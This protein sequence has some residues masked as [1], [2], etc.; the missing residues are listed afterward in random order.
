L[1]NYLRRVKLQ[2][3]ENMKMTKVLT[4]MSLLVLSAT[5][6]AG[7][8]KPYAGVFGGFNFLSPKDSS[9]QDKSGFNLGLKGTGSYITDGWIFDLSGGYQYNSMNGSG[10][11][12]KTQT[13]FLDLDAR[14]RLTSQL[15][16]GPTLSTHFNNSGVDNTYSENEKVNGG[17]FINVLGGARLSYDSKIGD[18]PVRY[19]VAALTNVNDGDRRNMVINFGISFSLPEKKVAPVVARRE[20]PTPAPKPVVKAEPVADVKVTLKFA[21]VGFETDAYQ[22]D[23]QGKARLTKLGKVLAQYPTLFD[24]IKISGHTDSRGGKEY[25]QK[26]SQDRAESVLKVFINAGVNEKKLEAVG[27][28]LTR[29]LDTNE[30]PAAWEKNRRTEIEFFGVTDRSF[31]N[32]KLEEALK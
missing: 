32:K 19:D 22:L 1:K 18:F 15:S 17:H 9:E 27:Y 20:V 8:F 13:L 28:G 3:R 4:L 6:Q 21:R 24:R 29:P 30:T 2:T 11:T 10:V 23:E 5:A 16:L 31:L 7:E 12:V 26:L 14:Y 25:N